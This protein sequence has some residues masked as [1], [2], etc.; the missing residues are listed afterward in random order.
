LHDV[1][2]WNVE[3]EL[4]TSSPAEYWAMIS[5]HVSLAVAALQRVDEPTRER[6]GTTAMAAVSAF[7]RDGAIRVPGLARC[8]VGT[9]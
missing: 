6:I 3:V 5:E 4:V 8:V 2:E 7:E 1:A 9:K